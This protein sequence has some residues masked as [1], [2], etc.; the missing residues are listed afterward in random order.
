MK[1]HN[2]TGFYVIIKNYINAKY[3]K[4]TDKFFT[5]YTNPEKFK[6]LYYK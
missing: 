5:E 4:M 6:Q 2:F 1:Y 3:K